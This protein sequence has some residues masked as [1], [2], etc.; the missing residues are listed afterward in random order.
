MKTKFALVALAI[1]SCGAPAYSQQQVPLCGPAIELLPAF[2]AEYGETPLMTGLSAS[3][4]VLAI[5]VNP[6]SGTWSAFRV[7]PEGIACLLD[8]GQSARLFT[9]ETPGEPS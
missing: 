1:A 4:F 6:T 8:V 3:G 7:T 9:P 5:V 2:A